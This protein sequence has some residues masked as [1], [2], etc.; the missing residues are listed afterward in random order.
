MIGLGYAS[1]LCFIDFWTDSDGSLSIIIGAPRYWFVG[2]FQWT[3]SDVG[4]YEHSTLPLWL[5]RVLP[6][7]SWAFCYLPDVWLCRNMTENGLRSSSSSTTSALKRLTR[8]VS[9]RV[10]RV[11]EEVLSLCSHCYYFTFCL[12]QQRSYCSFWTLP[13]F[14]LYCFSFLMSMAMC[15]DASKPFWSVGLRYALFGLDVYLHGN[16]NYLDTERFYTTPSNGDAEVIYNACNGLHRY[17]IH[18]A[19]ILHWSHLDGRDW[20]PPIITFVMSACLLWIARRNMDM[21]RAL[22]LLLI[23]VI[24]CRAIIFR[25]L[26]CIKYAEFS[27]TTRYT[28]SIVFDPGPKNNR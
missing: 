4:S 28:S 26:L 25:V 17:A 16:K 24:Y 3:F 21:R 9:F 15:L 20:V 7:C 8:S 18:G 12:P 10:S 13:C 2:V 6:C 27:I 11:C 5:C 22:P 1:Q 14:W 23:K 19:W